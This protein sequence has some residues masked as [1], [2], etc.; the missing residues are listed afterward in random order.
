MRRYGGGTACVSVQPDA[1]VA[2]IVLDLGTG[3]RL[4]GEEL[5]A[6]Y[7]P[8][9]G[10]SGG[11][12]AAGSEPGGATL[13]G[14]PVGEPNLSLSAFVTHLHFDHVQGLPFFGPALRAA[15]RL[16]IYGPEHDG[17][18]LEAA[19]AVFVQPPYFPVGLKELPAEVRW[20]AIADGDVVS[21]G[22]AV[23][24]AREIPHVG[25]TLGYRVECD[26]RSIAYLGDHQAP[27][28]SSGCPGVSKGALELAR[29]AD[30]LIHDAQYT[31]DEFAVKGHWG[32][33]TIDYAIEVARVAR[34]RR[35]VLFHHDPTHDD[36]FLDRLGSEATRLAGNRFEVLVA[37]EGLAVKLSD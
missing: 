3:S 10:L 22:E 37:A 30:V 23:V 31:A 24:R 5:V 6:R 27:S 32:H 21:V 11:A 36:D 7:F 8:G 20:H 28:A 4:L 2:P 16:D 14:E 26:G 29:E 25:R 15:T 1:D 35:L 13:A 9:E 17:A 33:S 12:P 18:S 19:F 34:V